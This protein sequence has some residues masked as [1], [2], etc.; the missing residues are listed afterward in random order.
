MYVHIYY[1]CVNTYIY[2]IYIHIH[3]HVVM[4]QGTHSAQ[5]LQKQD[6]RN[7]YVIMETMCPPGYHHI[8]FVVTQMHELPQR[9]CGDNN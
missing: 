8:G 7:I 9:H 4:I 3:I 2:S 6:R 1:I 5:I